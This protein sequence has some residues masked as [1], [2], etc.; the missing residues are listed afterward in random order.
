M[1]KVKGRVSVVLPTHNREN[2]ISDAIAEILDA[3]YPDK[4]LIVIDDG[5]TDKTKEILKKFES[6]AKIVTLEENSGTVSIPRNIGISHSTGEYIVHADD[7]VVTLP[8]KFADLISCIESQD[9]NILAYGDRVDRYSN[10]AERLV[11]IKDWNPLTGTGVDNSQIIYKS[12]VYSSIPFC[13]VYRAC[14][15]ELAKLMF[16][17]GKFAYVNKIVS[18]YL[19]HGDNRSIKTNGLYPSMQIEDEMIAKFSKYIN[20]QYFN[21]F[22][23]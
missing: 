3:D 22:L 2:F 16:H 8:D 5:S 13:Y 12:K 14:D 19:W 11:T 10:G 1:Q 18:I 9:D 17:L 21:H 23:I 7:D 20:Q 4:E 6:Y 15:W